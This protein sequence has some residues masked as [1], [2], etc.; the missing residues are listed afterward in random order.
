MSLYHRARLCSGQRWWGG[1]EGAVLKAQA[2]G[3]G[4]KGAQ[5]VAVLKGPFTSCDSQPN[6]PFR[7]GGIRVGLFPKAFGLGF[8]NGPFRAERARA[9]QNRARPFSCSQTGRHFYLRL[10]LGD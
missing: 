2:E 8:K 7:A 9:L 1:P 6:G 5:V 4:T 3:L 10:A